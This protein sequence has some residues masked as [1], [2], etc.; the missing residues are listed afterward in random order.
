MDDRGMEGLRLAGVAHCSACQHDTWVLDG[1]PEGLSLFQQFL[2][3]EHGADAVST[4][5]AKR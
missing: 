4:G 3:S 5:F 1:T 2:N